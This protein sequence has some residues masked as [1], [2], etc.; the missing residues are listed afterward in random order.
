MTHKLQEI[1]SIYIHQNRLV[2]GKDYKRAEWLKKSG[3]AR[4][5][6]PTNYNMVDSVTCCFK[7]YGTNSNTQVPVFGGNKSFGLLWLNYRRLDTYFPSQYYYD[8]TV[9]EYNF[10]VKFNWQEKKRLITL[11]GENIAGWISMS[12]RDTENTKIS[13][14]DAGMFNQSWYAHNAMIMIKYFSLAPKLYLYPCQ[15]LK[16]I[17]ATLDANSIARSAGEC[18]MVDSISGKFYG[19]VASSGSFS[20]ENVDESGTV[21]DTRLHQIYKN[22]LVENVDYKCYDWLE[23]KSSAMAQMFNLTLSNTADTVIRIWNYKAQGSNG[24]DMI[25]LNNTN[26]SKYF[27][28]P[29]FNAAGQTL[30][31]HSDQS[32]TQVVATGQDVELTLRSGKVNN[33]TTIA[34]KSIMVCPSTSTGNLTKVGRI[35]SDTYDYVPCKLLR[36]IPAN[37]TMN[38]KSYPAGTM[39]MIEKVSKKFQPIANAA[40]LTVSYDE[41]L[42][43]CTIQFDAMMYYQDMPMQYPPTIAYYARVEVAK[44]PDELTDFGFVKLSKTQ[45]VLGENTWANSP[46]LLGSDKWATVQVNMGGGSGGNVVINGT[47]LGQQAYVSTITACTINLRGIMQISKI[48]FTNYADA[49]HTYSWTFTRGVDEETNKQYLK[50][51]FEGYRIYQD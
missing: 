17:P 24:R 13:I 48:E 35:N 23:R 38:G 33:I 1:K 28:Y 25:Y 45:I 30:M 42:K 44:L 29:D 9:D 27:I 3:L 4:I 43:D 46:T 11:N 41:W 32:S 26:Q 51:D 8:T 37:R 18:G 12:K 34:Y 49:D 14:G 6:I 22:K 2:E 47:S 16:D 10:K 7:N 39:G 40:T 19:N 21:E 50:D 31:R 5:D 36:A 20:V 15:L